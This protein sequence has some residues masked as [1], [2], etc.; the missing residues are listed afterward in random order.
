MVNSLRNL[1]PGK[2]KGIGIELSPDR[3]SVAQLRKQGQT[4]KLE[5]L[6]TVPM[7]EGLFQEGQIVDAAG[8]AELIQSTLAENKLKIK[9]VATAVPGGRDTVTR[10]IPIP[11]ELNDQEL[12][13]MV[14][15]QEAGLYLP[16]PRE[17]ADVDYQKLG[18][19]VDE[20]GIEKFQVLLVATRKEITDSYVRTF[21]QA[22]LQIDVLEISSFSL[23]RTIRE[24]LRQF[25]PQEAVAI[26][27]IEFESTEISIAVDGVPQF[28]RTVPIG[29]YQIQSALSRAMNLPPSRSTELLQSMTI[30]VNP[31]D[32]M[33]NPGKMGGGNPGAAAMLR[34]I[35]ELADELRRSIDFYL[36]QGDNL[37]VAQLLLAGPGGSIGQLDEF[38]TQ[39]LSLPSSQIDPIAALGLEVAQDV[40]LAQRPG[41]GV[42][43]GLGLREA[44]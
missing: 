19:F 41:L 9:R 7:P 32:G 28:S 30:P 24:Q 34:I 13:E 1:L 4:F 2:P 6:A 16:F 10:I 21:Q 26:V 36:N 25:S 23:I 31:A 20:D 22:G 15:N 18:L 43:L 12:R 14:L 39:R 35:G 37:E 11:A 8:M 17:E 42:V 40:P 3:I 38:F 44:K 33:G 29:T 5:A 27:D